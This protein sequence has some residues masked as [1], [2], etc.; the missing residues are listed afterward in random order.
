MEKWDV[1]IAIVSY[2]EWP[3]AKVLLPFREMTM[4]SYFCSVASLV[5]CFQPF[6]INYAL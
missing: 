4:R 1:K 2:F 5:F 6:Y 3:E